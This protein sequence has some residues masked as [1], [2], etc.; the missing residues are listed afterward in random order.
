LN[1]VV[2]N[3]DG[4]GPQVVQKTKYENLDI[5]AINEVLEYPGDVNSTFEADGDLSGFAGLARNTKVSV[6]DTGNHANK[7]TPISEVLYGIRGLTL[8]VPSNQVSVQGISGDTTRLWN[9][10]RNH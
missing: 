1:V 4:N 6:W 8:L 7:D 3:R 5:Y 10:L 2:E 9:I